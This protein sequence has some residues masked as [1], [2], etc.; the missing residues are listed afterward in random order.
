LRDTAVGGPEAPSVEVIFGLI[1]GLGEQILESEADVISAGG[2]QTTADQFESVEACP[3][4][5]P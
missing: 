2:F 5:S 1:G 3:S 4:V